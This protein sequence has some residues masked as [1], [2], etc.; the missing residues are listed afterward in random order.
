[1]PLDNPFMNSAGGSGSGSSTFIGLSD[2]PASYA[3]SALKVV[4]VNAGATALEFVTLPGGG[5]ALTSSP[6]S[7]FAATTSAQLAGVISDE[8]GTGSLVF[9]NTPTLITPV[10]GA[11]TGTSLQLSGLT[12]SQIL[13]TDASKNLVSL[14]VATYPSL[15][16]LTYL[17]G[18]TSGIQTQLNAKIGALGAIGASPNANAATIS[19]ATLNLEPASASFGGVVTTGTQT[20]AG[21]KTFTGTISVAD[22]SALLTSTGGR[23]LTVKPSLDNLFL[24]SGA[25]NTTLSGN[26]NVAMGNSSQDNLTTGQLNTSLGWNALASVIGGSS[27][28][29]VGQGSLF[30]VTSGATNTALGVN[31]GVNALTTGSGNVFIGHFSGGY[32]S[33]SDAFYVNN[34]DRTNTAGDKTKSLLYGQFNATAASQQLT[35]NGQLKLSNTTNQ[36]LLGDP[37]AFNTVISSTA[38]A[39]SRVVTLPDAG[40]NS[41]FVLTEGTQTVNGAKTLS[42]TITLS[43]LSASLPLKTD[44]SKNIV[45]AAINLSGSEVT[46]NLPVTNLNS[47][48]SASASTFWRGDGS[49]ATPAGAGTVTTTGSPANGNLTKFSG[50]TSVTNGD[51]AGDVTTSGTLTTTVAAIAGTAV[52]AATGT[53]NVVF[54]NS[55]TLVTPVIGAATGTSLSVTGSL[56]SGT[57]SSAAG[58]LVLKNATNAFTQTIRGTNPAASITYDL[59]TTAP[60]AGQVLSSTAP[61]GA[62]ATL[63]WISAGGVGTVTSVDGSGGTTGLTLTGGPITGSGTLTLGGTLAVANGGTGVTTSTGTTNVVLSNSP[64]LVTPVLG[65]ASG[66]SLTLSAA[67]NNL[68]LTNTTDAASV[69]V[70]LL[71]GDRATATANDN[72]YQSMLLSDAAGTQVEVARMKWA[73]P[74]NTAGAVNG[75]LDFAVRTGGTLADELQLSGADLSPST[76]DGLALGTT[77]LGFSDIFLATGAVMDWGANNVV[78]THTSGVLTLGTGTL[79]ITTPTNTTTSVVT[80]DGTQTLTNKTFNGANNTVS[81]IN[82]ASQVTGN[83]PVTNLNSG[84]SASATT[85]W[86]GDGSWATPAGGG[87]PG[88]SDTQIQFNDAGAF[89]GHAAWTIDKTNIRSLLASTV[90]SGT[91]AVSTGTQSIIEAAKN[92]STG[93]IQIAS[94]GAGT[95]TFVANTLIGIADDSTGSVEIS[96]SA[97][98]TTTVDGSG[99]SIISVRNTNTGKIRMLPTTSSAGT[100]TFGG[101][102]I[103][104]CFNSSTANISIEPSTA[105]T[106]TSVGHA[107]LGCSNTSS[108]SAP[109]GITITGAGNASLIAGSSISTTTSSGAMLLISSTG[110]ANSIIGTSCTRAGAGTDGGISIAS[111]GSSNSVISSN[112]DTAGSAKAITIS[113]TGTANAIIASTAVGTGNPNLQLAGTAGAIIASYFSSSSASSVTSGSTGA[114]IGSFIAGCTTTGSVTGSFSSDGTSASFARSIIS[115][116]LPNG[117]SGTVGYSGGSATGAACSVIA[118]HATSN[119]G[120]IGF[121]SGATGSVVMAVRNSGT[122]GNC[123]MTSSPQGCLIA[124]ISLANTGSC[125]ITA[126]SKG[127]AIIGAD[128]ANTGSSQITSVTN[129]AVIAGASSSST[130]SC[131]ITG[132]AQGIFMGGV[133]ATSSSSISFS[134]TDPIGSAIIGCAS[135][136][137]SSGVAISNTSTA[138]ILAGCTGNG[139]TVDI[140][141]TGN[142]NVVI[143]LRATS[144][145]GITNSTTSD[146]NGVY[147][148]LNNTI[149]GGAN[150]INQNVIVG[151]STNTINPTVAA[152]DNNFILGG[153]SNAISPATTA[154][155]ASG[156]I[157]GTSNTVSTAA[158]VNAVVVGGSTGQAA[159][160]SATVKGHGLAAAQTHFVPL[161]AATTD[162]TQTTMTI[163][164]AAAGA[165]T[166]I[167]IPSGRIAVFIAKVAGYNSTATVGGAYILRGCIENRGGTT[168]I[169]G[170]VT[171]DVYEGAGF[172]ACDVVATA[173]DTND[174][175]AI[176]VTG[177]AA[178]TIAWAGTCDITWVG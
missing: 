57:A 166:R 117:C 60:T 141:C 104:G 42:G 91:L 21:A 152:T 7:Q 159:L 50:A 126:S 39:A 109:G 164:G 90:G 176:Q 4:R 45:S 150:D 157:G 128:L 82:L 162:A 9:A 125:N 52:S 140:G 177:I 120:A 3:G 13:A 67:G 47:G 96:S 65:V 124:G 145:S 163:D 93:I 49:W 105:A 147:S 121:S 71:Q 102:S 173:D 161:R 88:G 156:I 114:A 136:S 35:V 149:N 77:S 48:T 79:K 76:N 41:S 139:G 36:V 129:G 168:A 135:I 158:V 171:Q 143:G 137:A 31:S 10:I 14:A 22:N 100:L 167:T 73:I 63:S 107:I 95:T 134:G 55:P 59:P 6:L 170:T 11:A 122:T 178:T 69:Q 116:H 43:G 29:A 172:T 8:T 101:S 40:A 66:T 174:A 56:T 175:L 144:N 12:A 146:G 148:G 25:G 74:T 131:S 54:S 89:G 75:R 132:T 28:T 165:T 169:V 16:E 138:S 133:K 46:G 18:V 123:R 87:T 37:N 98:S 32:E 61:S 62:V 85:F 86:R 99:N 106:A 111:T 118:A 23:L 34:Q 15:T 112:A 80:I 19:G 84:T 27:N 110:T 108:S 103:L 78:L 53:T 5:D 1:M 20:F 68:S 130:G 81:N 115:C 153:S 64:T 119:S 160:Q 94:T 142:S 33:G 155:S 51:L 92:G 38:P 113:G 2:V 151:G 97:A 26:G 70:A 58:T 72:A 44:A 30:G 154:V 127:S 17:K 24:G 83:L